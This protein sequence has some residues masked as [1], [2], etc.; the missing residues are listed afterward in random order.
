M[1]AR[2]TGVTVDPTTVLDDG[3]RLIGRMPRSVTLLPLTSAVLTAVVALARLT[4]H[5]YVTAATFAALTVMNSMT[6]FAGRRAPSIGPDGVRAPGA[7]HV[8]PW[9]AVRRIE[10]PDRCASSV[11]IVRH[12]GRPVSTGFP[13]IFLPRIEQIAEQ[14]HARDGAPASGD[15]PLHP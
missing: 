11:L 1:A 10:A 7:A 4:G 12:D 3:A 2:L 8:V 6:W 14:A 13:S 5:H 15:L 9:T